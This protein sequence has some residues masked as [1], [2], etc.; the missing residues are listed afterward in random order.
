M[1]RPVNSKYFGTTAFGGDETGE[2]NFSVNVKLPS[3]SATSLGII[4]RQRTVNKFKVDDQPAGDGTE[5]ICTLVD[6]DVDSLAD[7]EMSIDA[8]KAGSTGDQ[9]RIKKLYNRTCR[10]FNNNR[11]TWVIQDDSTSNVMVVTAI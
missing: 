11:Y 3:R 4:L 9:V 6:K 7:N 5:G 2:G 1:G 8:V 10:D